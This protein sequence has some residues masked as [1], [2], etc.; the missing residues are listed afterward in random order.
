MVAKKMKIT[1]GRFDSLSDVQVGMVVACPFEEVGV[2][3]ATRK[4]TPGVSEVKVRI[5]IGTLNDVNSEEVY[6][7]T[8]LGC[9]CRPF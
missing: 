5:T 4:P 6:D 2:V 9:I 1:V 3:I 7:Y 8:K